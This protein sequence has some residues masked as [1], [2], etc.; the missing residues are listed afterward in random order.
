MPIPN[1]TLAHTEENVAR[2][3]A[4]LGVG[5]EKALRADA[6]Q[7]A[8]GGP[9]QR[10]AEATRSLILYAIEAHHAC[11][12]SSVEGYWIVASE[13][14]LREYLAALTARVHGI[15]Q[16]QDALREAWNVRNAEEVQM[17]LF[18]KPL[19]VV[20]TETTGFGGE[21]AHLI[22]VGL[23]VLDTDGVERHH[24]TSLVRVDYYHEHMAFALEV[25]K[26]PWGS[27]QQAP[28]AA[29]V[30]AGLNPWLASFDHV[31]I[32]FP[33]HFDKRFCEK[34][35]FTEFKWTSACIKS[36]AGSGKLIEVAQALGVAHGP[37]PHR[38]LGDA[39]LEADVA[40]ALARQGRLVV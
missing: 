30:A 25:N 39:R 17:P 20:D 40:R 16:R 22:E 10:T 29:A 19:V 28:T 31:A 7:A 14:E 35:G 5:R 23:V 1:A 2:L 18:S 34:A 15:R 27:I 9:P 13:A 37:Q 3:L 21:H 36:A 4:I 32:A 8:L 11:I 38:A 24:Y 6:I 33:T 12:A 26:I